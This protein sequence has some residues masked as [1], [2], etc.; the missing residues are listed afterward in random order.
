[1]PKRN[2]VRFV[3]NLRLLIK[4][5]IWNSYITFSAEHRWVNLFIYLFPLNA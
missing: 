2:H 1:M 5:F 3:D 4:P